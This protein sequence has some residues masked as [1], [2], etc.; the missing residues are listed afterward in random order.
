[1]LLQQRRIAICRSSKGENV[2]REKTRKEQKRK[3][4]VLVA[5]QQKKERVDESNEKDDPIRNDSFS[6]GLFL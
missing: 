3:K 1:M 5:Q 4:K 6:F 2:H